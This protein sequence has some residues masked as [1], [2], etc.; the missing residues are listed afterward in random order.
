M[1]TSKYWF[2]FLS[3]MAMVLWQTAFPIAVSAQANP[4]SQ[5]MEA[6]KA[7]MAKKGGKLLVALEWEAG[8]K[9]IVE[10]FKKELPAIKEASFERVRTTDQMQRILVEYRAGRIPKYDIVH[11]SFEAWPSYRDAGVFVKPPVPY[12]EL[13]KSLPA[14]WPEPDPRAV[15]REGYFIATAGLARGIVYN[16]DSVSPNKAPK[17]WEDCLDPTWRGQFFYDPRPKLTALQ[18]DPKTREAHLKWLKG[19]VE[20]KVVLGRGQSENVEKVAAGEHPL[21]CGVNYTS[22]M[23]AI[24]RGAPLVFLFPDPFPL[25]FGTQ[26]HIVKW[27]QTPATAQLFI[28][29]LATK[30]QPLVE[31]YAYRG[32]PWDPNSRKYPMARGKYAAVCDVECLKKSPDYDAEHARILGMPGA[33]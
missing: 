16:K 5:L 18:H 23:T 21:F 26:I 27:S 33:K 14:D 15:D 17:K 24:D 9:Q 13:L 4:F 1:G 7:E 6:S 2:S 20:N 3:G 19:I 8:G 29:W 10:A 25:E 28:T 32:F 22:A 11:V 12:K 30:A 31:K